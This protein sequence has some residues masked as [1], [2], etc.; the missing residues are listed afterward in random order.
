MELDWLIMGQDWLWD[1]A[2]NRTGWLI[3]GLFMGLDWL[4]WKINKFRWT[5]D[6]FLQIA[7]V[8]GN[9]WYFHPLGG[10]K[11]HPA[12]LTR[13]P[14]LR[15]IFSGCFLKVKLGFAQVYTLQTVVYRLYNLPP[16]FQ[17]P[18]NNPAPFSSG[19]SLNTWAFLCIAFYSP[20]RSCCRS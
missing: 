11:D 5:C 3:V 14:Q 8:T 15:V 20:V 10:G 2:N 19:L 6:N 1:W 12:E 18:R 7:L 9:W 16:Q 17:I 13:P 4:I